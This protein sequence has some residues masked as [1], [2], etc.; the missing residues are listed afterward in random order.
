MNGAAAVLFERESSDH[1]SEYEQSTYSDFR[2][3][4][5][6]ITRFCNNPKH[7]YFCEVDEDF[8]VDSFNLYGLN[9]EFHLYKQAISLI[10]NKNTGDTTNCKVWDVVFIVVELESSEIKATAEALYGMIHARFIVTVAGIE[11]MVGFACLFSRQSSKSIKV[12]LL[13]P[14]QESIAI[15]KTFS[16]LASRTSPEK[17]QSSCS[18]PAVKRFITRPLP[19]MVGVSF[20]LVM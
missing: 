11:A 19:L 9:G 2:E 20:H 6:W 10:L 3:E 4:T 12:A 14:A 18:V 1:D 8:I 5:C 17:A 15:T 7:A 16:L 13:E